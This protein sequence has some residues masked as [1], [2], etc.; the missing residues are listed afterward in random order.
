[1][2]LYQPDR[3]LQQVE[4]SEYQYP[5]PIYLPT[6][7]RHNHITSVPSVSNPAP[8][9]IQN[10]HSRSFLPVRPPRNDRPRFPHPS[11]PPLWT[12]DSIPV[13]CT[14]GRVQCQQVR[15]PLS[16]LFPCLVTKLICCRLTC[17][18]VLGSFQRITCMMPQRSLEPSQDTRKRASSNWVYTLCLSSITCTGELGVVLFFPF[19]CWGSPHTRIGY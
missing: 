16:F 13:E 3:S 6:I 15:V 14:T 4:S 12:M 18:S 9:F 19:P 7:P 8:R 2:R 17:N 10:T 11:L 5:R 1:M